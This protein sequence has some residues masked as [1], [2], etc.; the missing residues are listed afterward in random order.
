MAK[1]YFEQVQYHCV[2]HEVRASNLDEARQLFEKR[3]R[4]QNPKKAAQHSV[5][6]GDKVAIDFLFEI[7]DEHGKVLWTDSPDGELPR[8]E[9]PPQ[10]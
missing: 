2:T 7:K 5:I 1:F 8:V 6:V 3:S 9:E 10:D 4:T